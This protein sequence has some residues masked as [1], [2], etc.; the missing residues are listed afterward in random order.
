MLVDTGASGTILRQRDLISSPTFTILG[1][2]L[3]AGHYQKKSKGRTLAQYRQIPKWRRKQLLSH[4]AQGDIGIHSGFPDRV[5][6]PTVLESCSIHVLPH[7]A[8]DPL[9]L[10]DI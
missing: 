8:V 4:P 5:S 10:S 6:A 1:L 9:Q 7:V 3:N 2:M